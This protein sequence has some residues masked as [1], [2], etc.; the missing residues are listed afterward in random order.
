MP[1]RMLLSTVFL[2]LIQVAVHGQAPYPTL[3]LSKEIDNGATTYVLKPMAEEIQKK[4][5][6]PDRPY[7]IVGAVV[8]PTNKAAVLLFLNAQTD[9]QLFAQT[10][11][12]VII[13]ADAIEFKYAKYEPAAKSESETLIKLEIANVLISFDDFRNIA[14]A[15]SVTLK[16]GKVSYVVDKE[17]LES[18]RYLA[19]EI[20]RDLHPQL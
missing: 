13:T 3:A 20:E 7:Q 11:R 1:Q 15:K 6:G 2:F 5:G 19:T 18:L 14:A 8:R 4:V 10:D 9:S 12:S 16:F 17:N